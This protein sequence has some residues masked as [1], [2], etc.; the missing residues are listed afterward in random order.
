MNRPTAPISSTSPLFQ[1]A[2]QEDS[3]YVLDWLWYA[4]QMTTEAE[5]RYCFE[6]ALYID[7]RSPQAAAGIRRLNEPQRRSP[8]PVPTTSS[9]I[10]KLV[11]GL[12]HRA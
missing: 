1:Q 9:P 8:K 3:N 11:Q 12:F 2:L 4:G 6:R 10:G 5:Q 7:P